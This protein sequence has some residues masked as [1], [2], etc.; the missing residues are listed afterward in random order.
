MTMVMIS[1]TI[2]RQNVDGK[3]LTEQG[4]IKKRRRG[5]AQFLSQASQGERV[6]FGVPDQA[7]CHAPKPHRHSKSHSRLSFS[8]LFSLLIGTDASVR[9]RK[10]PSLTFNRHVVDI[11]VEFSMLSLLLS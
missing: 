9:I 2:E 3:R 11:T 5:M 6:T 1:M 7:I 10:S 8:A 4:I